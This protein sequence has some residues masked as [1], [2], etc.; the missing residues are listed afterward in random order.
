MKVCPVCAA[1]VDTHIKGVVTVEMLDG[2]TV[3]L[4]EY[5]SIRKGDRP[6]PKI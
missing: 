1:P 2:K 6:V 4:S 3:P 5:L